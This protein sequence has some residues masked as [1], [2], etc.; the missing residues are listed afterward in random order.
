MTGKFAL[1]YATAAATNAEK[2]RGFNFV[3]YFY[4]WAAK[5]VPKPVPSYVLQNLG[6]GY[7]QLGYLDNLPDL[8]A[9]GLEMYHAF[10][11]VDTQSP[12]LAGMRQYMTQA[13]GEF[14]CKDDALAALRERGDL[15]VDVLCKRRF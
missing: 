1:D 5:E 9:K 2:R 8:K 11:K 10:V 7:T 3:I 15:S 13:S 6:T 4:E 14:D 12:H